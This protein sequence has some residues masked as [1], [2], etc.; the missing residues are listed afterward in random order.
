MARVLVVEDDPAVARMLAEVCEFLGHSAVIE[1]DSVAAAQRVRE[2]WDVL[3]SDY[4]MP[5]LDGIE[6]CHVFLQASPSTRRIIVTA[7]P[8]EQEVR[9]AL[10]EGIVQMV[11]SKPTTLSDVKSALLWL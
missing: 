4:L 6:L 3:L 9:D 2:S 5:R 1:T 8:N 11:L 10:R 7:A